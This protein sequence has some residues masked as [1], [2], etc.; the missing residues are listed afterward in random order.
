MKATMTYH[1]GFKP[2]LRVALAM[3]ALATLAA[4]GGCAQ[5]GSP[6]VQG[7]DHDHDGHG[8]TT[9]PVLD[10]GRKWDTDGPLRNG[11]ERIQAL[12]APLAPGQTPDP[13]RAAA[14]AA[15]VQDQIAYLIANCK[16]DP[17]ADAVL[18][19]LLA[20]LVKGADA[21]ASDGK[22]GMALIGHA[23]EQYPRYFDHPGWPGG[24]ATKP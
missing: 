13:A 1:P 9:V 21:L 6:A 4:L 23:L 17:A 16:L 24:A 8:G 10:D 12:V 15:G 3:A 20:D 5:P 2:R 11:M 22:T 7:H 18:H 14:I 19:A